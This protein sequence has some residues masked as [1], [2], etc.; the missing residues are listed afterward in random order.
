MSA[1][2]QSIVLKS[3]QQAHVRVMAIPRYLIPSGGVALAYSVPNP[4]EKQDVSVI[5]STGIGFGTND[6]LIRVMMTIVR[7]D[8]SI[9]AVGCIRYTDE[10]AE[11][12]RETLRD[13]VEYDPG[14]FPSGIFCM[15]WGVASCCRDGVPLGIIECGTNK[16]AALIYVL[17]ETPDDV[18]NRILII[19]ERLKYIDV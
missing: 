3:L 12:V 18:A 6:P 2:E 11:V 1:K 4:R 8:V 14:A 9:R 17:G 15:N 5:R 10:I 16:T 7:F 19:S 13:V